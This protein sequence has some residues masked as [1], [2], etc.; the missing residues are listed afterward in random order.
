MKTHILLSVLLTL[1]VFPLA[2]QEDGHYDENKF[3]GLRDL[4]PTPNVYRTAGGAPGPRYYQQ[5]ADYEMDIRIDEAENKLYG[6]E[7]ITYYNYSPDPLEYLWVQLDQNVRG[8]NSVS[9]KIEPSN[10]ADFD[11]RPDKFVKEFYNDFEGGFNIEYVRTKNNR[12]LSHTINQTMMR[13]NLPR[14]LKPGNSYTFKIKWWYNINDY[15]VNRA[16]SGYEPFDEGNLY[17]I[18]Q[19]YPRMAVYN[20]VEGWQNLQFFGRSEFAL[21]FGDYDVNITVPADHVVGATGKL[22]N[23][24]DVVTK[25]QYN[26][27]RKAKKSTSAPTI[28][29]TQEEAEAKEAK[30]LKD[31]LTKKT[32]TWEFRAKNV[33]DFGFATSRKFIWDAMGVKLGGKTVMAESLYPKEGNPLWEQYSTRIVAHTLKSYSKFTFNY[34]YHKAISV[35]AKQQGMEYPM[36]CWNYGRPEEDGTY[37]KRTKYGMMSVIIHEIGHNFFPMI[38]N[39]DERKWGWMDEGLNTFLQYLTEQEW[40]KNYPSRR[41][42]ARDIVSYMKGDQSNLSPIMTDSDNVHQYG[43]NAYGKPATALNILRETV[44][45]RELFDYAFKIYSRR[46]KFKHPTPADFFRTMEDASAVDL[47]WFWRGWFYTTDHCDIAI[48]KVTEYTINSLNPAKELAYQKMKK[49]SEPADVR[50]LKDE[51]DGFVY[52]IEKDTAGIDFYNTYD[53]YEVTEHDT[54]LYETVTDY[55]GNVSEDAVKAL[56]DEAYFYQ[57]DFK[58]PGGLVMPIILEFT[59]EDGSTMMETLPAKIWRKNDEEVSKVFRFE[60]KVT[61]VTL[62]PYL[63]TADI[64]VSNNHWPSR[65]VPSRFDMFKMSQFGRD[66]TNDM[67]KRQ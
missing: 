18:A 46:W 20:D 22:Q 17:V 62:D 4:L 39:S 51:K 38:V 49:E 33:R 15:T 1:L 24:D 23:L 47:D 29:V 63:E 45:G 2:A 35:H 60:K 64:D 66:D 16:R 43:P 14:P 13:I 65:I 31:G 9:N 61:N 37:S 32:H 28:V 10:V 21:V 50:I 26:R 54:R 5:K 3:K 36:I 30:Y 42:R 25:T 55:L 40:E 41:G 67:Q 34:P 11:N 12:P 8:P 19:F 58:K 56:G 48:D 44:M 53:P 52:Q 6:T 59:F 57:V 7:T 27:Y